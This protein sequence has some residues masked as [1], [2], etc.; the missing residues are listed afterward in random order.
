MVIAG[1][2][3]LIGMLASVLLNVKA[4]VPS[5]ARTAAAAAWTIGASSAVAPHGRSPISRESAVMDPYFV[6]RAAFSSSTASRTIRRNTASSFWSS[7]HD[8]DRMST[9]IRTSVGIAFTDVPPATTP[10]L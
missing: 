2:P 10:T 1:M 4:G 3:R 6:D 8:S 7:A 9:S 5:K